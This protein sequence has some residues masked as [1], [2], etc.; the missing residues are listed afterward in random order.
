VA[1]R[2]QAELAGQRDGL[3]GAGV[4]DEHQ[5]V[6][7]L[8]VELGDRPEQGRLGI[9]GGQ[10]H[11]DPAVIQHSGSV[12]RGVPCGASSGFGRRPSGAVR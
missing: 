10:H 3:V 8:A 5:V 11:S 6:D 1:D 12:V 2:L 7:D 9:V 4:I